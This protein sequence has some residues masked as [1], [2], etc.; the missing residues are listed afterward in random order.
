MKNPFNPYDPVILSKISN[1]T[2]RAKT[3]AQGALS[4]MHKSPYKG[5][6]IEF[7]E[8]KKY[9][10]GDDIKQI[11]WKLFAKSDRH[12]IKQFE[13]ETNTRNCILLDASGSM[14]YKSSNVSKLEYAITLAASLSY[15]FIKQS[16]S[17]GFITSNNDKINYIPPRTGISHFNYIISALEKLLPMGKTNIEDIIV[18]FLERFNRKAAIIVISDFFD[19]TEKILKCLKQFRSRKNEVILFQILDPYELEFPFE[20]PMRFVSM[21]DERSATADSKAIKK[22]YIANINLFIQQ[23]RQNCISSGIDYSFV[24]TSLPVDRAIITYLAKRDN[25]RARNYK[26]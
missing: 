25:Q 26:L 14:G 10:H 12:Y 19:D 24:T 2:I 1:L 15:L 8:H 21:E 6:G 23:L 13:N 18:A 20:V 5:S 9:T 7:L 22:S 4:G 16:D 3:V 11:D 17:I